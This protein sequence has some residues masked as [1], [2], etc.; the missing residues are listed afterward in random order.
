MTTNF[1][2]YLLFW[3]GV[4]MAVRCPDQGEL[5]NVNH[6]AKMQYKYA[7]RRLKRANYIMQ[8]DKFMQ[9]LLE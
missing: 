6:T 9:S 5:Y 1:Y 8:K 3:H 7:V 4:W 2:H